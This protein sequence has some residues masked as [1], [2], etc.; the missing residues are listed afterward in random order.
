M[1][2]CEADSDLMKSQGILAEYVMAYYGVIDTMPV[3]ERSVIKVCVRLISHCRYII[4]K[5]R[6]SC[7]VPQLKN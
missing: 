6:E 1:D 5:R 4:S 3:P 7:P 2:K